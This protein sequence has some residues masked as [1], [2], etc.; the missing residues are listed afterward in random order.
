MVFSRVFLIL[1]EC[2]DV[3]GASGT[4]LLSMVKNEG[5]NAERD[6][7]ERQNAQPVQMGASGATEHSS[8]STSDDEGEE[9]SKQ[10]TEDGDEDEPDS[11]RRY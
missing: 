11:K 5:G 6:G 8:P 7:S 4:G 3:S 9:G 10:S 1:R 2:A